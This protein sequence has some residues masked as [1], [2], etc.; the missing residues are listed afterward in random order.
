MFSTWDP[1][2][3]SGGGGTGLFVTSVL[4]CLWP[5]QAL[6]FVYLSELIHGRNA[7]DIP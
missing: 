1:G 6:V 3:C 7:M 2:P 5:I 4:S